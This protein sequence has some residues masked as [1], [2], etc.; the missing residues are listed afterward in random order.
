MKRAG[1]TVHN[2]EHS[3]KDLICRMKELDLRKMRIGNE[4]RNAPNQ[5]YADRWPTG[6][7]RP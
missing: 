3:C 5:A 6:P 2:C 4:P 7:L 1:E